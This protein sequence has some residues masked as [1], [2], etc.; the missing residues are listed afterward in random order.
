VAQCV[1]RYR[2]GMEMWIVTCK[3]KKRV[4]ILSLGSGLKFTYDDT[5]GKHV[6]PAGVMI[7]T[8]VF[9]RLWTAATDIHADGYAIYQFS[10][11]GVCGNWA[12]NPSNALKSACKSINYSMPPSVSG[13]L[14]IGIFSP[15]FQAIICEYHK[16][17]LTKAGKYEEYKA[18]NDVKCVF[19]DKTE[20]D[21]TESRKR[22]RNGTKDLSKRIKELESSL[23]CPISM[24]LLPMEPLA[25]VEDLLLLD[26]QDLEENFQC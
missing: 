25:H 5:N 12:K 26:A 6:I 9:D 17:A 4:K 13:R 24:T 19:L 20:T 16:H 2:N 23:L 3:R 21:E 11:N 14:V 22:T 8:F 7:Q 18:A 10:M 1:D 15:A